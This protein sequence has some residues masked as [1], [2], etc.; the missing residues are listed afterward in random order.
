MDPKSN[1]LCKFL[2]NS[3][4]V[5]KQ[6]NYLLK[7]L[8]DKKK[9]SPKG[10][11]NVLRNYSLISLHNPFQIAYKILLSGSTKNTVTEL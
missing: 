11:R 10:I 2:Q 6:V 3:S 1:T 9:E 7:Y 5:V 8:K 4:Y